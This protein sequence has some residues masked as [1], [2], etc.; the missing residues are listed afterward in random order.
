LNRK[1]IIAF[2]CLFLLLGK[3]DAQ[4]PVSDFS[5][6]PTSGCAP[7]A[8]QFTDRSSNS[9]LFW[10]WDFGDGQ[11]STA[12]N[13]RINYGSPG[14]YAVT[15][16]TRNKDG[17]DTKTI[18]GYITVYPSPLASFTSDRTLAC[19]PSTINFTD[20]STPSVGSIVSY[21]WNFGDGGTANGATPSHTYSSPGY[22][23][24]N[25]T[26]ANSGGCTGTYGVNRY[27]R[28]VD[29][30]QPNFNF[31]QISPSCSAPYTINFLNQTAG[32]GTLSY[33]WSLGSGASPGAS[34]AQNPAN[35]TYTSSGNYTVTLAVQSS[36][37]CSG[38][39]QK[40][41]TLGNY[42][43]KITG[44]DTACLNTAATFTN[45]SAPVP[46]NMVWTFD[47]GTS[48]NISPVTKTFTAVGTHSVKLL[49]KFGGC[50]DSTA[51]P[52]LVIGAPVVD[53]FAD[54]TT[55]CA[56]PLNVQ[57]TDH[58]TGSPV[59]WSWDFGDGSTST[60][61]SPQ[62]QYQNPGT[63][64]VTL[65]VTGAGGCP[66]TKKIPAYINIQP[67][68]V[69]INGGGDLGA[70]TASSTGDILS[71][72]PTA[73]ITS[74]DP[75]DPA[76][77]YHW[78][79]PNS[80]E[81]TST[82]ATP[83]FTYQN[84]GNYTITLTITTLHGCTLS[85][86]VTAQVQIGTPITTADFT[87]NKTATCGRDTVTFT[88]TVAGGDP[89][90]AQWKWAFGD[91]T[92][93]SGSN[94]TVKHSYDNPGPESASLTVTNNGCPYTVHH[95]I[96]ITVNPPIP[97]F[98]YKVDCSNFKT[99]TFVDTSNVNT[100]TSYNWDY[101]DGTT[102]T[103]TSTPPAP[104]TYPGQG[105][106]PVTLTITDGICIQ[107]FTRNVALGLVVPGFIFRE[108]QIGTTNSVCKHAEFQFIST[109]TV[110]TGD[111][112]QLV[113]LI[114]F[115]NNFTWTI[116]AEDPYTGAGA[117]Y[118]RIIDTNGTHTITMTVQDQNGCTYTAPPQTF[119]VIGPTTSFTTPNP[120]G[121]CKNGP[122]PITFT[123]T[124]RSDPTPT[125]ITAYNWN[126]GDSHISTT[127]PTATNTYADTGFY[128]I[129]LT[130]TDQN[131]CSDTYTAKDSIKIT[132][133][134][135][136][137]AGPDSFYCPGVPLHFVDSSQ[138]Y[139]LSEVWNYGDS[140]PNDS[141]VHTFANSG[142]N[143][144][145][146]LKVTDT[147]N[148]TSTFTRSV[149]IQKPIAAFNIADTTT[150]CA[151]LQTL[152][153]S[154]SKFTD[155]LY[156]DFGDGSTSTLPTTSHFYNTYDTFTATLHA[157][158]P[159]GCF[160]TTSR[161]VLALNPQLTTAFNY[162]PL[163]ACDSVP[164]QFNI[165]PPGYTLFTLLF[166]DL[167]E[168]SSQNKTPFHMYRKPNT[169]TPR[170]SLSDPTGCIV[171][172]IGQQGITVLGAT[173]FFSVDKHAFC[174]SSIVKFTDF[175][176]SNDGIASE[177]YTFGDGSP[178]Q[179]Q[180]P[181]TGTFNVQNYFNKAGAWPVDLKITT[182]SSCTETYADTV[183]AYQTPH[184]LIAL[185]SLPCAGIVQFQ[186][187]LTAPQV[188]TIKWAWNFGNGQTGSGQNPSVTMTPGSYHVSLQ[189][190]VSYGCSDTTSDN[191]TINPLPTIN[192]P[193]Q[194]V[195]PLGI[196]I[197][198]PLT[199]GNDITA[200]NWSPATNLDCSTCPNPVA[201]LLLSTE[202]SVT[203]TDINNCKATDSIFIKTIC[204]TDNLFMPNTFS[205]NGDGV[206]DVFYPRGK[207]LYNVQSLTI[208]NRWG[209]IVF[210]R[211]D[212]P[213]NTQDMGWD[214][215]F[216]GRPAGSDAYVY[217][218]EVICQNAQTVAI[219]GTVTL[220]R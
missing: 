75:V 181:G 14:T 203:V 62:H 175:T 192:G 5:A 67:P 21:S 52:V 186:G 23:S 86:P 145:V 73:T 177:T 126:F 184:P 70:C 64:D 63:Y 59:K 155:S 204:N 115:V 160:D 144:T 170:L 72:S 197:T 55:A 101:G 195:T 133:P 149:P 47:D 15:L 88:G 82:S 57:F 11:T 179:T 123:S 105:I 18:A 74:I 10:N 71:V 125:P 210:Q 34:T 120:F 104:H 147:F 102:E 206:N 22:Y 41:L 54:K 94:A 106:Y 93:I 207:S 135:A 32:P 25:L 13:P 42:T 136:K 130:T 12:Q 174:D 26:V 168:D 4:A 193:K 151:P 95:N 124:T 69:T 129:S 39:T 112:R 182:N 180:T 198:I 6:T 156:W 187:S 38:S 190:S 108:G 46:S 164:V 220:V 161:R 173:P 77:G 33:N 188:D 137:F 163:Q 81:K 143:Y 20:Q 17:F 171:S 30:V 202:Y 87:V 183:N 80:V 157:R 153:T 110:D 212:F 127:G 138:G 27:I 196:P 100:P 208:F 148:C 185:N 158:G 51:K 56:A 1:L 211:K 162:S 78:D 132:S 66:V 178:S 150:I 50:I 146:T 152:F 209:Q 85:P 172:I 159:G 40:T 43:T 169:Y 119:T 44:P 37:G 215:T 191:F 205:P 24:V 134:I 92:A 76:T 194:I 201:T 68:T 36:L 19:A 116:D 84:P 9:P 118:T 121:G 97:K 139:K 35:I 141:A 53:F 29:G 90:P 154:T 2:G 98:G 176:I 8:V 113:N 96:T 79:A 91:G 45:A 60:Q 140:G 218:V 109:T 49:N 117:I 61:Q 31:N 165:T 128:H 114:G 65:T 213:A 3:V 217:I 219:H 200:Y 166:A 122:T 131:G 216:N 58:T 142:T 16:S 167:T 111:G 7:L 103:L 89:T 189:A 48:S 28:I 83:T 107:K 99:V 214:G 199:Y